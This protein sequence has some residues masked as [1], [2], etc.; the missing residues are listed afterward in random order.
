MNEKILKLFKEYWKRLLFLIL[1]TTLRA[2]QGTGL[3]SWITF[4][5][6]WAVI[7]IFMEFKYWA[8]DS[9]KKF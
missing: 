2:W 4:I 5:L 9:R 8:N 6:F 1:V 7:F 3:G